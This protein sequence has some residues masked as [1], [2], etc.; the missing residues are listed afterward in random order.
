MSN[1]TIRVRFA[2]SPTGHLH[3]GGLRTAI[4]NWLFARH[5]KG[6]F[7]LRM[8]DT[9]VER[10]TP[11][12]R[13][14]ILASLAWVGLQSDEPMVSQ[15]KRIEEHKKV[16]KQLLANGK[17]Y[18]CF[19]SPQEL[20]AR[21]EK[22]TEE[23]FFVR[24]DGYCRDRSQLE[25]D[26][27]RPFVVRF[28]L[29]R[30]QSIIS[31]D[32][33]IRGPITFELN[34]LDDFIIARSDGRPMYNFAVVVDDAFMRI[35]QVIRGEDHIS[36]TPKQILLY[37]ACN[38]PIP[39][40]AHL[41]LILGPSGDRLSKRDGA[42]SVL[43]YKNQGYL[44]GALVNYLVRLGWAHGDQEIFTQA[45]LVNYFSLDSVGKKGAIFDP[46]KL[47]WVNSIY[48]R[49]MSPAQLSARIIEDIKSD[50]L[51]QLA[52]WDELQ[53]DTAINLYKERVKTLRELIQELLLLRNG[54]QE[55]QLS[56]MKKWMKQDTVDQIHAIITI[57]E[58]QTL[59]TP[60]IVATVI[61]K[62]AKEVGT[63]LINLAQPIRIALIG[64]DSGPGVFGL[65]AIIGKIESIRRLQILLDNAQQI[66]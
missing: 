51:P 45:A 26:E 40:F 29:P 24:Y 36:N 39:Q 27:K 48:I 59:F 65:L 8:E 52:P 31:F 46:E 4:F 57:L 28:A 21:Y 42:L 18:R 12:Y 7:L 1:G 16:L 53:I 47:L 44:A 63:K 33:L 30:D 54:P 66:Q 25:V 22:K 49:E 32:D 10:S 9:D 17:V 64:K 14:S 2:P 5:H 20:V 62:F 35:S 34:E 6:F 38:Y 41:P 43:E 3:V 11:A 23:N 60:K 50:F 56:D 55:F 37:Q 13:D 15:S 61:K 19:C 58:K